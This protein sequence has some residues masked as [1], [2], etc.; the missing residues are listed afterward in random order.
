MTTLD[1]SLSAFSVA[2]SIALDVHIVLFVYPPLPFCY[3]LDY[4]DKYLPRQPQCSFPKYFSLDIVK[5]RCELYIII[6]RI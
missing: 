2:K 5:V 6:T 4:G 1:F 3:G